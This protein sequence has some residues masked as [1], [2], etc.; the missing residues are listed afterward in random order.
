MVECLP[1]KE[2]VAGSNPVRR[3]KLLT[4]AR[5]AQRIEQFPSKEE[6]GGSIPSTGA[7]Q[8]ADKKVRSSQI[9]PGGGMVY[10][11]DLKSVA[12]IRRE[13]SSPSSGTKT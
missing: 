1:S 9:S 12:C 6:V 4:H 2:K 13:G 11:A 10:A 5:V 3:S 7:K 8:K